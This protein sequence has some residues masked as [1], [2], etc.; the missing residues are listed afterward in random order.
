MMLEEAIF[1][2][3]SR[4]CVKSKNARI[5]SRQAAQKCYH[6]DMDAKDFEGS[7]IACLV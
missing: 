1:R 7:L 4:M 6:V 2:T 3:Y 5:K